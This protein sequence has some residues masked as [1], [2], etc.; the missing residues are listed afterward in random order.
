MCILEFEELNIENTNF[1]T[2]FASQSGGALRIA[3]KKN[4]KE[5]KI[6]IKKCK[7]TKNSAGIEGGAIKITYVNSLQV[8]DSNL[9]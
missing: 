3:N 6:I 1:N 2:L 7:F 8:L 9:L 5:S 4:K